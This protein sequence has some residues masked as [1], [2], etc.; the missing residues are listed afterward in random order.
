MP[1]KVASAMQ[2]ASSNL[3]PD[4]FYASSDDDFV[5]DFVSIFGYLE[6]QVKLQKF[7]EERNGL[8][9]PKD[10]IRASMPIFCVYYL[11]KKRGPNRDNTSKWFINETEY[12]LNRYPP[13]CG[14]GFYMMP[15]S[16][17]T[18][19]YTV[20]RTTKVLAMDDVWVTGVLRQKLGRGDDNVVKVEWPL[21]NQRNEDKSN[22]LWKHLWG[23][24]GKIK[25]DIA[26][27]LPEA[28]ED[29]F[30]GLQKRP[31]CLIKDYED[32]LTPLSNS[33]TIKNETIVL[34]KNK[35]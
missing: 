21:T 1:I 35:I 34:N 8:H 3:T 25:K 17:A 23:D 20:S 27:L 26:K 18:D 11:D 15:V 7:N 16:M 28:W 33:K 9:R 10:E 12:S 6:Y 4:D 14:G 29:W 24:Y 30:K 32:D 5:V 13:Y 22:V 19:L 2:W 31:Y